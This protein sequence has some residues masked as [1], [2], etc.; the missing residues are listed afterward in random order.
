MR[1]QLDGGGQLVAAV[2]SDRPLA[3]GDRVGLAWPADAVRRVAD[4][5]DVIAADEIDR[6]PSRTRP[7]PIPI[8]G[9]P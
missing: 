6:A 7:T 2:R 5:G 8:V 3:E 4:T 9:I 1:V